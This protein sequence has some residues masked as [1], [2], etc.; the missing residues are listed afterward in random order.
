[1]LVLMVCPHVLRLVCALPPAA[2]LQV[3]EQQ[4][5][6]VA[7][8][9]LVSQLNART[10]ILA[11]ANPKGSRCVCGVCLSVADPVTGLACSSGQPPQQP[12]TPLWDS[13]APQSISMPQ[14][15]T[16]SLVSC[17]R[18][19]CR[20]SASHAPSQNTPLHLQV[21]P[22]ADAVREHQPAPHPAVPVRPG[23]PCAGQA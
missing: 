12:S 20:V 22:G 14:W 2:A 11:C 6:S 16:Q 18:S 23:L 15:L 9:G 21:P 7:K 5:V 4:T 10:S 17:R 1:M 8:A 13:P 3:M 19:S